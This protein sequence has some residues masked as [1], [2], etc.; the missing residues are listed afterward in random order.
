MS[1][2]SS[3]ASRA[4][5]P[6]IIESR[7]QYRSCHIHVPHSEQRLPAIFFNNA[8]YS[9]FKV[10]KDKNRAVELSIR[11]HRRGET[12]IITNVSRGYVIWIEEAEAKPSKPVQNSSK[13][14]TSYKILTSPSQYQPCH[15]RVPDLNKPIA[16]IRSDGKYYSLFKITDD[17]Q[18]AV[19]LIKRLSARGEETIITKTVKG[20]GIWVFEPEAIA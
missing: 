3:V 7:Q 16:A 2:Q 8:Y 19:Q 10:E 11:L 9:F 1:S 5:A 6:K 4:I 17:T 20:Y 18:Q 13:C 12:T 14:T 15:I